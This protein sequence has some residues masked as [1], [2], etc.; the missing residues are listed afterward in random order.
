M[1]VKMADETKPEHLSEIE[2]ALL[3]SMQTIVEIIIH[4]PAGARGSGV[5]RRLMASPQ[6]QAFRKQLDRF[7]AEEPK[8]RA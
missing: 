1:E 7:L 5:I 2:E 8:G 3:D 6:G 4:A